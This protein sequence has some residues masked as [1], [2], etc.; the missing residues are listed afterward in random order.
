MFPTRNFKRLA[1]NILPIFLHT[2]VT[3]INLKIGLEVPKASEK[4]AKLIKAGGGDNSKI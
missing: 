1:I 2:F 3:P 4:L